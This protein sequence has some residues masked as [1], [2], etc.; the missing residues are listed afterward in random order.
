MCSKI[1]MPLKKVTLKFHY[2]VKPCPTHHNGD[3]V[4]QIEANK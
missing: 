2:I 1:Q 3:Q 4:Y